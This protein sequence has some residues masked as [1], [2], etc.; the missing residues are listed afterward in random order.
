MVSIACLKYKIVISVVHGC[1]SFAQ[2]QKTISMKREFPVGEQHLW[3]D[4]HESGSCP[5]ANGL[6]M[7]PSHHMCLS[8]CVIRKKFIEK[9]VGVQGECSESGFKPNALSS[10]FCSF[11]IQVGVII[12]LMIT[13]PLCWILNCIYAAEI[14][15]RFI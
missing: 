2:C 1:N 15:I 7:Q 4:L 3:K 5:H 9:S 12:S 10:C 11:N 14:W 13:Y 6:W 8:Q